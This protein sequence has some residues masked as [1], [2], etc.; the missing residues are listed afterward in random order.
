MKNGS[1]VIIYMYMHV[2]HAEAC[3]LLLF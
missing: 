3:Q 1:N 2:M